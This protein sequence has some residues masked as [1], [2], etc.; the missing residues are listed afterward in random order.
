MNSPR[1]MTRIAI[2]TLA[3]S[4]TAVAFAAKPAKRA[5]DTLKF[6]PLNPIQA[7]A[8]EQTT[9]P[10]GMQL[11]L[12]RDTEMP[13]IQMRAMVRGGKVAAAVKP[14]LPDLFDEVF[15]TG[16]TAAMPGDKVDEYLENMG[17]S[18]ECG[19]A[20][21]YASLSAKMLKEHLGKVLPLYADFLMKPGFEEAK[22]EL[23]KTQL[24]SVIARRNDEPMGIGRRE[25]LKKVFGKGSP[26]ALQV[27]Y[28]DLEAVTREDM[29]AFH[30]A[31]F[32]PDNTLLAV[33]GDFD[34]AAMKAQI[35]SA[36]GA[37][38]GEGPRFPVK[39]VPYPEPA[40]SV[41]Y[42]E[43]AGAEQTVVLMGHKGLRLDDPDYP[44]IYLMSEILGGGFSSRIFTQ[45]RTL[46]GLAYGAGGFMVPAY[47]R[48]GAFYFY[49]STKPASTSETISTML[50]EIRKIRE[51]P[52][53][54]AELDR[55]KNAYLNGYAFEFDS[56]DKIINRQ[57]MYL[58]YGYP[59]DF[60]VKLRSAIETVTKEQILAA[61]QK[62]LWPDKLHLVTV[63]DAKN[64]DKPLSTFGAVETLDITIPEPKPKEVIPEATPESLK[65]GTALLLKAAKA[66][67]EAGVKS[68]KD[69]TFEGELT[70]KTPMGDMAL[71]V[72]GVSVPMEKSWTELQTP[73]GKMVQAFA[74]DAAWMVMGPQSQNMPSSAAE[75][76]KKGTA[77][78]AGCLYLLQQALL[79]KLQGQL[80][81]KTSFEGTEAEDVLI[82]LGAFTYRL[83]IGTDGKV[84]GTKGRA[85][86][87]E[88]PVEAI[89][90]Y[91]DWRDAGG[92]KIPFASATKQNGEAAQ[93]STMTSIKLNA[94][95]DATLFEKPAKK[96]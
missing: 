87:Q 12:V 85:M 16:G 9:L 86:T 5:V 61:A 11:L 94:G 51:A 48:P 19:V 21:S 7:P 39:P 42:A 45:V 57:M 3:L 38:K 37:W 69:I 52:V 78:D 2:A 15:R 40:A 95:Y 79:G 50:E 14:A 70:M 32:R 34:P 56:V 35:E 20:E 75:E 84:L 67:G 83:Y 25:F 26:Y 29:V 63:G 18:I 92:V 33:W 49:S 54:D 30:R 28:D 82:K 31:F 76:M 62:Y 10:N 46:K 53:T 88:G 23:A 65:A 1:T 8:V 17:A 59:A 36:F 24:K 89:E 77:T 64:F 71:K 74:G 55:V 81:G 58:L 96:E 93:S 44:A 47:D 60:N 72:K 66:T 80:L 22:V 4:L 41:S 43:K 73:M 91:S 13:L 90:I 6:P 27:E 68:L